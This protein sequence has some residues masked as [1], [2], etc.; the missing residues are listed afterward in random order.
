VG[1]IVWSALVSVTEGGGGVGEDGLLGGKVRT[2]VRGAG[3]INCSPRLLLMGC[4]E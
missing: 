4:R 1:S 3:L 2:V